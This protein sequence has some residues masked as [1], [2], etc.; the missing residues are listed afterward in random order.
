ML[1]FLDDVIQL[2]TLRLWCHVDNYIV[3][4]RLDFNTKGFD[5][6]FYSK[7]P[8]TYDI[9]QCCNNKLQG[10]YYNYTT[11]WSTKGKACGKYVRVDRKT[12]IVL[13]GGLKKTV[14]FVDVAG[15][16]RIDRLERKEPVLIKINCN[17]QH[18]TLLPSICLFL[19]LRTIY[20]PVVCIGI[21]TVTYKVVILL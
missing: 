14:S 6:L 5:L 21:L 11:C 16:E 19:C 10:I 18:F 17:E 3:S 13:Y 1:A 7:E 20:D 15:V 8:F 9:L 2:R 12:C 4:Y